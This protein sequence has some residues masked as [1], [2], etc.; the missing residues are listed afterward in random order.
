M[1][2]RLTPLITSGKYVARCT[3]YQK[4]LDSVYRTLSRNGGL[5]TA[6]RR[7]LPMIMSNPWKAK[8]SVFL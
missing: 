8:K 1:I 6:R 3:F 7:V 2:V 5:Q 4:M